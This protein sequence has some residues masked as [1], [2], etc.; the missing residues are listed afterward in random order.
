[1]KS[2]TTFI[3]PEEVVKHLNHPE[4]VIIDCRFDLLNPA[5]GYQDYLINHIPNAIYA[6]LEKDLSGQVTKNTGR[7]PLPEPNEFI[8]MC[9]KW[10]IDNTKQVIVYDTTYG[11]YASRLWW[12][13]NYFGHHQVAILEGGFTAWLAAGFPLSDGLVET[14]PSIFIGTPNNNL[15]VTTSSMET[16]I[17]LP[18]YVVIDARSE[19]RYSGLEEPID[20]KAGHIPNAVNFFHGNNLDAQGKLLPA[21]ELRRKYSTFLSNK[22]DPAIVLYCG[23]GVTSCLNFAVL[24][25][26]GIK[27]IQLYVGSWSEWITNPDHPIVT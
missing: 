9:S 10:G 8:K 21:Q 4:L 11:S 6:D 5:W 3:K 19:E 25:H 20:K 16:L 22:P 12:M 2:Y 17:N 15:L 26:I 1:M 24:Q 27:P 13:L 18:N 7:H 23:S 14:Q